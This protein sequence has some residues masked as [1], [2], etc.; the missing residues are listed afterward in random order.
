MRRVDQSTFVF[1]T[2]K[3]GPRPTA[4][5]RRM[6]DVM[7]ALLAE[8]AHVNLVCRPTSPVIEPARALGVDVAPY[9]LEKVNLIRTRSRL[10]KYLRRYDPPVAHSIGTTANLL[11]R[12]A[13]RPLRVKVVNSADCAPWPPY[14]AEGVRGRVARRLDRRTVDRV[15]AF[16]AECHEVV[17]ELAAAGADEARVEVIVPGVDLPRVLAEGD[18]P[19]PRPASK[20]TDLIAYLGSS[21][22]A[23]ALDELMSAVDVLRS[24]GREVVVVALPGI[25]HGRVA[26]RAAEARVLRSVEAEGLGSLAMCADVC[27]VTASRPGVPRGVL[28]A[29]A[30]G[31]PLV[32]TAVFGARD[33]LAPGLEAAYV[34]PSDVYGLADAL[35]EL[36]DDHERA[37][38]MGE[39]ARHRVLD[40]YSAAAAVR[41]H[42]ELYRRLMA[43]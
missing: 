19:C 36:L 5:E 2:S 41:K 29:G 25:R 8:G 39:R 16:V 4:S 9:R 43:G 18:A 23:E 35:R 40:E 21:N 38:R 11:L 37:A 33:L 31:R 26:T 13:A 1:L 30:L 24:E 3:I 14:P 12:L 42:L 27:A 20:G 10:R 7:E 17:P 34:G 22:D 6:L 15:D 32:A 28:V